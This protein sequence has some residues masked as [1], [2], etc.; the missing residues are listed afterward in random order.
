[1]CSSKQITINLT[2]DSREISLNTKSSKTLN[3]H[4]STNTQR[5]IKIIEMSFRYNIKNLLN[6]ENQTN[7]Y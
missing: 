3:K 4:S 7:L 6:T 1:M 2:R 5:E